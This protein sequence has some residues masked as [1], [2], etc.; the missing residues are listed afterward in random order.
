MLIFLVIFSNPY[1]PAQ[2]TEYLFY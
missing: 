2:I 1:C